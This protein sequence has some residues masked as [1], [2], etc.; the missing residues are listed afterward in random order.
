MFLPRGRRYADDRILMMEQ[1]K[2]NSNEYNDLLVFDIYTTTITSL[3]LHI[4]SYKEM[5]LV[6][7]IL[8]NCFCLNRE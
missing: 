4:E 1:S 7:S 3:P 8:G 2:R 5:I 6:E